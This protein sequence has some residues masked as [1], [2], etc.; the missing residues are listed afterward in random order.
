MG[1][2]SSDRV[3]PEN[4][5]RLVARFRNS[6]TV[7]RQVSVF[8]EYSA[9]QASLSLRLRDEREARKFCRDAYNVIDAALSI[10]IDE[11][12]IWETAVLADIYDQVD[13]QMGVMFSHFGLSDK[14][15]RWVQLGK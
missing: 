7:D 10:L 13:W 15:I 4:A 6:G 14:D 8:A 11:G 12:L 5:H 2:K 9:G 1:R 3:I